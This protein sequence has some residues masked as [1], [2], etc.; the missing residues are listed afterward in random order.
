MNHFHANS[1]RLFLARQSASAAFYDADRPHFM[2][3]SGAA[4]R[5]LRGGGVRGA[6]AASGS[7]AAAN[8]GAAAAW[9]YR[10]YAYSAAADDLRRAAGCERRGGPMAAAAA[11]AAVTT[12]PRCS[13][14]GMDRRRS[15]M[16]SGA[17]PVTGAAGR[18]PPVESP[19]HGPS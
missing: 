4:W 5:L 11:A 9:A 8:G 2:V 14:N 6:A 15:G 16:R 7:A 1:A 18:A 13:A 19:R 10:W 17:P 3:Q 12:R